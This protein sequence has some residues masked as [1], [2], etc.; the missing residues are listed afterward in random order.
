[1]FEQLS[2]K[3]E[4]TFKKLKGHARITPEHVTAMLREVRL[5]LLEADVNYKVTRDLEKRIRGLLEELN[6]ELHNAVLTVSF[7]R[8]DETEGYD[9]KVNRDFVM[10]NPEMSYTLELG[11]APFEC[12]ASRIAAA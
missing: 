9:V 4:Q 6:V 5:A 2:E 7:A 3:L 10:A 8:K 1:M 12:G 11:H